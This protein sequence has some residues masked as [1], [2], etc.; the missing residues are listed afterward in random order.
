MPSRYREVDLTNLRTCSIRERGSKVRVAD[1]ARMDAPPGDMS[2]LLESLPRIL[3]G[4]DLRQVVEEVA[5]AA[6]ARRPVIWAMGAHV[7]KCGLSPLLIEWLR[8]GVLSA[9]ALNGAGAIHD[10]EIALFG[11]TSEDVVSGLATGLFGLA[12]ETTGFY[13]A[14]AREGQREGWGLG[15]SLGAKLCTENVPHANVSVLAT[16]YQVGVPVTV[17]V[18]IGTDI[19][20]MPPEADGGALGETSLR[21]FRILTAALEGLG[22]GGVLFNVGSAVVLPEVLLKALTIARNLGH[23]GTDFLGINFDFVQNYRSNQQV[24]LRVRQLGARG[25]S[26]TGHHEILIPLLVWGVLERLETSDE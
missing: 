24:V 22:E 21:D 25:I 26:L 3:A 18:G 8:R 10:V 13:N 14:A 12:R 19:V 4:N 2:A 5:R 6:L 1:F 16:A 11:E 7:I 15:E 9:V 20:H 17:H 23:T